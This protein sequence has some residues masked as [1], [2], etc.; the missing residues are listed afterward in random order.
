VGELLCGG[1]GGWNKG[2]LVLL[3][4]EAYKVEDLLEEGGRGVAEFLK[5][6]ILEG[7]HGEMG[8][9]RG[10]ALFSLGFGEGEGKRGGVWG[11]SEV[12][13]AV[14]GGAGVGGAVSGGFVVAGAGIGGDRGVLGWGGVSVYVLGSWDA[15]NSVAG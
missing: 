6:L 13:I 12:A 10:V 5:E 3:L 14:A 1:V 15:K 9:L 2:N 4:E 11:D 7:G 8:G